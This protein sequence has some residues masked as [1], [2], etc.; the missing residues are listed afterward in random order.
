MLIVI[1][2]IF[3]LGAGSCVVLGGLVLIGA[4]AEEEGADAGAAASASSGNP[5]GKSAPPVTTLAP[6]SEA[7]TAAEAQPESDPATAK[8]APAVPGAKGQKWMCN[9][10]G[11][12]RVCGFANVCSNQLVSGAGIGNDRTSASMMAKNAC[13]NLARAKGG[14]GVCTVACSPAK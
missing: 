3:V 10:T 13:E 11:W 7:P 5:T 14:A 4:Q 1:A 6:T 2:G 8:G 9:A 12:V